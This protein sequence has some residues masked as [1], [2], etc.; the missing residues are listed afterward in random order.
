M[1]TA[2]PAFSLLFPLARVPRST[3]K[4]DSHK[5]SHG[6]PE[7]TGEVWGLGCRGIGVEGGVGRGAAFVQQ[8]LCKPSRCVR[9]PAL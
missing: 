8:Y 9:L 5:E 1:W 3:K 2:C 4:A 7:S 6:L